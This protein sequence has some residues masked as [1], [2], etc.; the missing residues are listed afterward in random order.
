MELLLLLL[1][2][3][4][5][6]KAPSLIPLE[7]AGIILLLFW[8]GLASIPEFIKKKWDQRYPEPVDQLMKKNQ[9]RF[10][11][12]F[13]EV[14]LS[15]CF[16]LSQTLNSNGIPLV[17]TLYSYSNIDNIT[18]F[19]FLSDRYIVSN[20]SSGLSSSI[21]SNYT[22]E[23]IHYVMSVVVLPSDIPKGTIS[24][25]N[26]SAIISIF[27][28]CII[29]LYFFYTLGKTRYFGELSDIQEKY[30]GIFWSSIL[31][32]LIA[33]VFI[34]FLD[35]V[36]LSPSIGIDLL[37][38]SI[39]MVNIAITAFI[40]SILKKNFYNY[41]ID[42]ETKK[43]SKYLYNYEFLAKFNRPKTYRYMVFSEDLQLILILTNSILA[44]TYNCNIFMLIIA[45]YFLLT[46]HFWASQL[47]LLP[48]RKFTIEFKEIDRYSNH[49]KIE[50]V[51]II[52][53]S[54][55]GYFV[56]L[57]KNNLVTEIMKDSVHKLIYES[58]HEDWDPYV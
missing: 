28:I 36:H 25:E 31:V 54:P 58:D 9:F 35:I 16:I 6:Y 20:M 17:E 39:G 51:F 53:E 15:F 23:S 32:M 38:F 11:I 30:A 57:Q 50:N 26:L 4:L 55:K 41:G 45:E 24:L 19:I 52:S 27:S 33:G 22:N 3:C 48:Y 40:P 29:F 44:I 49:K 1:I 47:K 56:I 5:N 21:I 14:V 2:I 37:L 8:V 7:L 18:N 43:A 10:I 46:S 12:V 42:F 13:F 34:L